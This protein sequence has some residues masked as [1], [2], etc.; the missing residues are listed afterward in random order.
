MR[1]DRFSLDLTRAALRFDNQ[2]VF[3]RPKAFGVLRH[4]A[5]NAGRL[6]G[7]HEL[8]EIVWPE[9]Q[10]TDDSLVQCVREL[11]QVLGDKERRLIKTVTRRGYLLDV[12]VTTPMRN[13]ESTKDVKPI[14]ASAASAQV[15]A[16]S[17][18]F[19]PAPL[20][21]SALNK[22]FSR[23][24]PGA[25]PRLHGTSCCRFRASRS[26]LRMTTF[27]WLFGASLASG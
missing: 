9:V 26:I 23:M 1:F 20:S 12:E 5:E 13:F 6:V 27:P 19:T 10:V 15:H 8:F 2:E 22:L 16:V 25:S 18:H 24:M 11:R 7:K 17:P 3:L 14:D 4:L 21:P